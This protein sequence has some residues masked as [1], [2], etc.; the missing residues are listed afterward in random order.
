MMFASA[1]CLALAARGWHA[2]EVPRKGVANVARHPF[3]RR[4]SPVRGG[5]AGVRMSRVTIG[6]GLRTDA[7]CTDDRQPASNVGQHARDHLP[8]AGRRGLFR[9]RQPTSDRS[10]MTSATTSRAR[11]VAMECHTPFA[12]P[13]RSTSKACHPQ[14][15]GEMGAC[16]LSRYVGAEDI[17]EDSEPFAEKNPRLVAEVVECLAEGERLAQIVR[18][19]LST[20]GSEATDASS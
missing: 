19:R 10:G 20:V 3:A 15:R 14:A 9:G 17:E 4:A 6:Q 8:T 12:T 2:L 18:N 7:R 16:H 13:F 5:V 11:P 1:C